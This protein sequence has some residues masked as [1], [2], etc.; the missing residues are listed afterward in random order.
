MH[1]KHWTQPSNCP[2]YA[3][4]LIAKFMGPTWGPSGADRTQVGPMLATWT[5]LSGMSGKIPSLLVCHKIIYHLLLVGCFQV[6]YQLH[7]NSSISYSCWW[8]VLCIVLGTVDPFPLSW[9]C[10]QSSFMAEWVPDMQILHLQLEKYSL[11]L[12]EMLIMALTGFVLPHN[13]TMLVEHLHLDM[14]FRKQNIYAFPM[15]S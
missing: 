11:S 7:E 10:C 2:R 4:S 8:I 13:F 15:I 12:L 1:V 6:H 3:S 5:L 14:H 9:P